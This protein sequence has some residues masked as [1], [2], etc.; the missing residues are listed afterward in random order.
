MPTQL[1]AFALVPFAA[2]RSEQDLGDQFFSCAGRAEDQD[3]EFL[4]QT[5]VYQQADQ[6]FAKA[7]PPCLAFELGEFIA[8]ATYTIERRFG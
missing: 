3:V 7:S 4:E 1:S 6:I 5:F 2:H 8:C